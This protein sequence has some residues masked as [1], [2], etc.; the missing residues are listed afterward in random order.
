M[1]EGIKDDFILFLLP[2]SHSQTFYCEHNYFY[3]QK[4]ANINKSCHLLK[5]FLHASTVLSAT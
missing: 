3:K 2:F 4:D 1:D 5:F